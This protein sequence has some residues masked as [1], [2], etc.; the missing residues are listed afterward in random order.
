[1]GK[2]T[3]PTACFYFKWIKS[4]LLEGQGK[5]GEQLKF[6]LQTLFRIHPIRSTS[7]TRNCSHLAESLYAQNY[8]IFII[9]SKTNMDDTRYHFP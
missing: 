8:R 9:Y 7:V 6:F 4:N 5:G 3:H 1:M 2:S